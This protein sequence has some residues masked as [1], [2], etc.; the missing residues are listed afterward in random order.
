ML[1]ELKIAIGLGEEQTEKTALSRAHEKL[2]PAWSAL[3]E[4]VAEVAAPKAGGCSLI[5]VSGGA[6]TTHRR[7]A[8]VLRLFPAA[9]VL[10]AITEKPCVPFWSPVYVTGARTGRVFAARR[11]SRQTRRAT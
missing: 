5:V 2:A 1:P 8:F 10:V 9:S 11:E 6:L 7:A 4:K 3:N